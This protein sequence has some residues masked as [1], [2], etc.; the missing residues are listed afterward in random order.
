[1]QFDTQHCLVGTITTIAVVNDYLS[2]EIEGRP[3]LKAPN[4]DGSVEP[5][6]VIG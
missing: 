3:K 4:S 2:V 1:M 6:T 5:R